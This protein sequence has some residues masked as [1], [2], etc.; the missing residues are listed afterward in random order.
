M[1][2]LTPFQAQVLNGLLGRMGF[3]LC[4]LN[5]SGGVVACY[6][7]LDGRIVRVVV[8]QDSVLVP[9]PEGGWTRLD[10]ESVDRLEQLVAVGC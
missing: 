3:D 9:Q 4:Y 7:E 5:E 1:P 10:S 6:A 8:T 2:R